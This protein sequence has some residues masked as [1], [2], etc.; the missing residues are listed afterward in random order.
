MSP[1]TNPS[2]VLGALSQR[3]RL[4]QYRGPHDDPEPRSGGWVAAVAVIL[5]PGRTSPET[6]L[7]ERAKAD[8]DPWSGHMAFPGGRQDQEDRSLLETAIRET[9]EETAIELDVYGKALG[10]LQ[11]V[12]PEGRGLPEVSILPLVFA[13]P[14]RTSARTDSAEVAQTF[15]VPISHFRD[16]QART[17]YRLQV[18]DRTVSFPAI[19]IEDRVVWGLTRRILQDLLNRIP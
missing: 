18:E 9:R 6:L 8:E 2:E 7:I 14:A 4:T 1:G 10:Q 17:A 12:Q 13:V 16:S 5:R 3:T 15:W 11:V 19:A